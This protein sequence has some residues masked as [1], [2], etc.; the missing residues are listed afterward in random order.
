[1]DYGRMGAPKIKSNKPRHADR[2]GKG[3]PKDQA[4]QQAHKEALLQRM[5]AAAKRQDNAKTS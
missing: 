2:D 5:K 1:M 3:A 4:G